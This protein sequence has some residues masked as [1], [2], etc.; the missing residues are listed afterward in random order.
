MLASG[1]RAAV[2]GEV[3][4]AALEGI[5]LAVTTLMQLAEQ[6]LGQPLHELAVDGGAAASDLLLQAQANSSGVPVRRPAPLEST[7]ARFPEQR[8]KRPPTRRRAYEAAM[9]PRFQT[10]QRICKL[11]S[12]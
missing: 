7:A 2:L 12:Y 4:R 8:A 9:A 11:C 1:E 6:A 5:A 10:L 3:T